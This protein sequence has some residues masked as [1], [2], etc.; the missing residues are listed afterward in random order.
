MS[1]TVDQR[2]V[3]MRFDNKQFEGNV[4]NTLSSID[5]L[6]QSLKFTGAT[7]GLE[8]ISNAAKKCDLSGIDGSIETVRMK[9]SALQVAAVTALSNITNTAVNAGKNIIKALTIDPITT[10]FS[11]YETKINAIQTIMSN[12]ASKG[13]TMADVTKVIDELNTYADK[14][15]Y[16]FAEMTRNIGT[17]TA[18]GVGLEESAK[19]IQGIAN[20]AAASG[21]NS[22]QASTAMYQLSQALATGTIRLMDW[23][24]VV[25]AGMGGEKFQEAIKATA[26]EHGVAVDEIIADSGSFRDSLQKEWLSAD[27]LNETL[28]KFTVDGAKNYAQSMMESGKWTQE[29]ADALIA[30]AQ[31]MEDAATKVKTFTQLWDTLKEAAQS[32]WGKTWEIIVGD[33]DEAKDLFTEVSDVLGGMINASADARNEVLSNGLSSGWNQFLQKGISDGEGYKESIKEVAREHGIAIDEM[34][35]KDG[36]FEETLKNGWLTSDIMSESLSTFADKT[37]GLSAE[38]LKEMGYTKEQID[39]LESLEESV[40]NGGVSLDE[41][42]NKMTKVSGRENL[43]Q[44]LR[45]TFEGVMSV[46]KP[47]REAFIEIFPPI[48]ANQIYAFTEGLRDLTAKLKISGETSDKLK[49]I[50]KGLFSVINTVKNIFVA[51]F[52]I[53]KPV[54]G[55]LGALGSCVLNVAAYF[56][57]WLTGLGDTVSG[58]TDFVKSTD[59][60]RSGFVNALK[61]I[62]TAIANCRLFDFFEKLWDIVTKVSGNVVNAIGKLAGGIVDSFKNADFNTLFDVL[63][64]V[65]FGAIATGLFKFFKSMSKPF[66]GLR[67]ILDGVTGILDDVR[68]CLTAYQTELKAGTLLKIASAV[69]ILAVSI[70]IIS[71]IDSAK[72]ASAL[73]GMSVLFG[74][75]LAS[76]LIMDKMSLGLNGAGKTAL[77][78]LGMSI[79]ILILAGAMKKISELDWNGVAKGLVTVGSLMIMLVGTTK[80]LSSNSGKIMKGATSLIAFSIAIKILAGAVKTLGDLHLGQLAKGLVGVGLLM[81]EISLFCNNTEFSGKMVGTAVGVVIMAAGLKIL[82]SAVKDMSSL[83]WEEMVRGLVGLGGSLILLA[84]AM[85][86][87]PKGM[88]LIGAGL[89]GVSVAIAILAT[90]L[91]SMGSMSWEEIGKGLAVLGGSLG[92]L[93]IGLTAMTGTLAG[94]AALLVAA[95]AFAVLTPALVLLGNMSWESIAKG[96]A[97]F[98][99]ALVIM[100]VAGAVLAPILPAIL[101]LAGAIALIGVGIVAL[102]AGLLAAGIG[103]QALAVGFGMLATMGIAGATAAVASLSI[104]FTGVAAL[105]PMLLTKFAEGMIQFAQVI[106]DGAPVICQA[107][108]AV[109]TAVVTALVAVIP[110]IVNGVFQLLTSLLMALVEYT[111]ILV[112][113]I[114]DFILAMLAKVAEN[115][116]LF[117]QAGVDIIVSFAMGVATAI[118]QLVD[119]GFQAIIAFL[120]GLAESIRTNMPILM[121]AVNNLFQAI[122]EAGIAILTGSIDIF[123]NAGDT[124]MNSG[125]VQGIRNTVSNVGNAVGSLIESAK[126]TVLDGVGGFIDS[127]CNLIQGLIDGIWSKAREV[128]SAASEIASNVLS[129][130]RGVFDENS[131]SK[132]AITITEY[133]DKGLAIGLRK[134]AGVVTKASEYVGNSALDSMSESISGIASLVDQDVDFQPTIRPVID[135]SNV[136]NGAKEMNGLFG[137]RTMSLVSAVKNEAETKTSILEAIGDVVESTVKGLV[138][139]QRTESV[140]ATYVIEVP[141]ILEGREIARASAPYT[142]KELN[143]LNKLNLRIG[144]V[145]E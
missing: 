118:P 77:L 125:L 96:L 48:T 85:T 11:E 69:G 83:S 32:G 95:A 23:N 90:A 16:N 94:S 46:I 47:L 97:T 4:R 21:S 108:V 139:E 115:I 44:A 9:F 1:T 100:G 51:L 54:L 102:G 5:R 99:G 62:G 20:L 128:I 36:S 106:V 130:I 29:Q 13:T 67:D 113:G 117:I 45:N 12:T 132:E 145:L 52:E 123:R 39:A 126:N 87:M 56:S 34:I 124:I 91:N 89:L 30:E 58:M 81:A 22:Q 59:G 138:G 61:D 38:Q 79:S 71:Q 31:A 109:A 66:E 57:G 55:L 37:R 17:F 135:L 60:M 143:K 142:Q 98:A 50:F 112:Q 119:A 43:I 104:I 134:Y 74:E 8:N 111:P 25:N 41:F 73:G 86:M 105:I 78:M 65:S 131:P 63:N 144:G 114:L 42:A 120:N 35:D 68:G 33:F 28:N 116:P 107:V 3:S 19:A 26:R 82:A 129:V 49:T 72:L 140:N 84:G 121:D 70:L 7:D 76:V 110:M 80:L 88:L 64:T 24:S 18:A 40:K 103:M 53:I 141:V 14:T 10:G 127:G 27:I 6:K 2:V 137:Q 15:I 93:A 75:L 133:V 92:I 136:Q 101:G 122:I